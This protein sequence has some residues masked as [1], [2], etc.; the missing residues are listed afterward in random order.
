MDVVEQG[1]RDRRQPPRWLHGG[2]PIVALIL[3]A[4]VVTRPHLLSAGGAAAHRSDAAPT[5]DRTPPLRLGE[6]TSQ[7]ISLVVRQGDHLERYEAGSGRWP[8][9]RLPKGL[10]DPAA[11]VHA[12]LLD[13]SGLLVGVGLG[14][15]FRTSP[16]HGRRVTPIGSADRVLAASPQPGRLFVLLRGGSRTGSRLVEL[17]ARTG[18]IT[19]QRPFPGYDAAGLWRPVAVVPSQDGS[20]LLLTRAADAG[21]AE[22]ALALGRSRVASD[23][24]PSDTAPSDNA[25]DDNAPDLVPIGSA[26]RVLGVAD[27]RILTLDDRP[28]TCV[29]RGCPITVRTIT[30][31]GLLTREVQPPRGWAFG[32]TVVGGEGGGDPLVLVSRVGDPAR[33]ALARL[34]P[35]GSSG[36]LVGG[37]DGLVA[38][39]A[40]VGD[41]QGVVLFAVPRPEGTRVSVWFPGARSAALLLDLPALKAGAEL[42]CACR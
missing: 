6:N 33:F 7:G 18:K 21:R 15:L 8:L 11:F 32:T 38:S 4:L 23:T 17:D 24:A 30:R 14:V 31:D 42:V 16:L 37:T 41:P 34:A 1:H 19:D 5:A 9:A 2:A 27:S 36:L 13:G 28:Q 26:T 20:R 12:P 29:D 40:P 25:P 35:G 22:L 3:A 39:I 10:P